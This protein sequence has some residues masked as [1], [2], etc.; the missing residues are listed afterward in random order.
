MKILITDYGTLTQ[1]G[2]V[3]LDVFKK[4]GE[5]VM[6]ENIA[7][8][9]LLKEVKDVDAIL[10]NK[11]RINNAVMEAAPNLKFVGLFATGYNNIDIEDARKH[12][13]T[14]CNA[15]SYSTNAVAQQTFAFI[16]AHFNRIAEYD[17]LVKSGEWQ[18]STTFS[19][20]GE[21]TDEVFGK[22][23][24]IVG[25]GSIGKRVADLALAFGMNVLVYNRSPRKDERVTFVSLDELLK[26]SDIVTVHCPLNPESKNMFCKE[27]F[28]KMKDGAFF[29]NTSRGALVVEQ[30]LRDELDSGRISAAVDVLRREPMTEECP[31]KDA[32]NLI[33][34]PHTG[35]APKAT[36]QR[37]INIVAENIENYLNGTPTN[38]VS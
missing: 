34:T 21:P 5:T 4:F 6:I 2:D 12:N 18:K 22:T 7:P 13:I 10:C 24:G 17:A 1:S 8:E 26:K 28:E 3:S 27:S 11:T 25:Y 19:M 29:I 9:T 16:L 30:D 15:G 38:V 14:V 36:R 33:I 32:P 35:W 23:I 37:L 31:L 20:L